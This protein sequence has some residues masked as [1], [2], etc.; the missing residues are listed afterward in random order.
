M[1]GWHHRLM[2][3]DREAWHAAIHGVTK[4]RTRL[5]ELKEQE[6]R[7]QGEVED[8]AIPL[9]DPRWRHWS[10]IAWLP[11]GREKLYNWEYRVQLVPLRYGSFLTEVCHIAHLSITSFTQKVQILSPRKNGNASG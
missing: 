8:D 11:F 10:R 5:T 9:T 2:V 3:M 6:K 4:S 7:R 1:A